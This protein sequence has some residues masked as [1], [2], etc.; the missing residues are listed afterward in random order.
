[1]KEYR[2]KSIIDFVMENPIRNMS[3][4]HVKILQNDI[5]FK[6]L[7]FSDLVIVV[8]VVVLKTSRG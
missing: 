5:V 1:M 4:I 2:N 3:I 6:L 8:V 7:L